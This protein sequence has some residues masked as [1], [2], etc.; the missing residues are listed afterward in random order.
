[1]IRTDTVSLTT[2][3]ALS[4]HME[5]LFGFCSLIKDGILWQA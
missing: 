1:M 3:T 5:G 2:I 4:V